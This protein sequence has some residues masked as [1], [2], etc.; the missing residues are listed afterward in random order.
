[1]SSPA[2]AVAALATRHDKIAASDE[3]EM[4]FRSFIFESSE[5]RTDD[6]QPTPP[7]ES[8]EATLGEPDLRQLRELRKLSDT[9]LNSADD[10]KLS[11]C[12]QL[13]SKLL[14]DGFHPILWCRYIATAD[15]LA[16]GLQKAL[17]KAHPNVRVMSITGRMGDEERK[18]KVD[19]LAQENRRVLVA[20]DCLS[21]GINLQH[22]FNAVLHYDLPWNP[23]RLEQRE[24]R[25]DRFGQNA[26]VVKAIR[27]FSP[28]SAV[29]GVVLDVLLNKA[30]EIHRALGTHVPVPEESESVTEAL[31]HA[32]FLRGKQEK[33]GKEVQLEL[34]L[35]IPEVEAF[36]G[37]WERDAQREKLSRTRFAQ[38]ALKPAEVREELEATDA[39]LGDPEAVREFVLAAGQRLGPNIQKDRHADVFRVAVGP[40]WRKN[41]PAA[42]AFA[43]PERKLLHWLISFTSPTPEGAEYLGR[44]HPF[45]AALARFLLEEALSKSGAAK[46]TRCGV[47]RTLAVSRLCTILLLRVRY[48]LKQPGRTELLSEEVMVSGVTSLPKGGKVEWL[49]SGEALRLLAEARPDAN[50]PMAEKRH[51]IAS[52]LEA[53]PER[54]GALRQQI[55]DRARELEQSHKRVRKAVSLRVRELSLDP[56]LP[57]D[58]LGI[59]VLQPV[60]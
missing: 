38:R 2:A 54:E 13:V 20:T 3:E 59:L 17:R 47:I 51:L 60:V 4:D 27:Y 14:G 6:D 39:V 52:A 9:L 31:L 36:H 8:T 33:P 48:L 26:K 12:A 37:R 10:T 43:L 34:G 56:Q 41:L 44:N 25:V 45:V 49:S 55:K 58:L 7:V 35:E 1:M 32:L 29:D 57:P 11:T 28:D 46:A 15:Y 24:G 42:I 50:V 19:E 40:D 21:E 22:A 5:D 30:R 23:N 16:E 53:W 18:A